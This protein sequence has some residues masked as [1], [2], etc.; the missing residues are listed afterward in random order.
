MKIIHAVCDED[1]REAE[2]LKDSS[3][4]GNDIT[5]DVNN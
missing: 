2:T 3:K 1:G 4:E 5:F